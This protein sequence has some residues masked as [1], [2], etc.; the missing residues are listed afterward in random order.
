MRDS[1]PLTLESLQ[2]IA[3]GMGK[4]EGWDFRRVRDDRDPVPWDYV[5]IVRRYVK[6]SDRV[7][8]CGTGGGERFLELCGRSAF[9]IGLDHASEMLRVAKENQVR[10]GVTH[11]AW[12]QGRV[13]A[14]PCRAASID[15]VLNRHANIDT[16]EILRVLRPGGLFVTQQVGADNLRVI[17]QAFGCGPGGEYDYDDKAS[18]A[19]LARSLTSQGAEV[20]TMAEYNVPY[21]LLDV[22]SLLFLLA[23][24]GIP[25]DYCLARHWQ[26]VAQIVQ[27]NM[28]PRGIRTNEHRELL[29]VR[30][31]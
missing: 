25:E 9:G 3:A 4:R 26:Q 12:I 5:G 2:S 6:P 11:I 13:E 1:T 10:L 15:L 17:C 7:L 24:V 31:G 8:D 18:V 16:G 22:A 27:E 14:L 23:G 21:Y 19:R 30:K 29:V 28:T 20:L